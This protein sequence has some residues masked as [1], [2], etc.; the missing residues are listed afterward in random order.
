MGVSKAIHEWE[1]KIATLKSQYNKDLDEEVKTAI[2][3]GM[4]PQEYKT[5]VLRA[6][7]V[8]DKLSYDKARDHVL[9]IATQRV[10]L[11][12]AMEVNEI[13]EQDIDAVGQIQCYNG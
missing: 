8:V 2:L 6:N 12:K 4:L 3:L 1:C 9:N 5:L 11:P 13:D 10:P 7:A